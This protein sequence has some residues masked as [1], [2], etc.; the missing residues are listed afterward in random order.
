MVKL[1]ML[2]RTVASVVL[3]LAYGIVS[4]ALLLGALVFLGVTAFKVVRLRPGALGLVGCLLALE[5]GG[6][7]CGYLAW[8]LWRAGLNPLVAY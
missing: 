8:R 2:L 7:S 5:T 6:R 3:L 1:F 4:V